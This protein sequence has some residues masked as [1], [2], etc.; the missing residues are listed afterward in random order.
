M[1]KTE[2]KGLGLFI[3][4]SQGS[5]QGGEKD[6]ESTS[7]L[8]QIARCTQAEAVSWTNSADLGFMTL[9]LRTNLLCPF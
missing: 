4:P 1:D 2:W 8:H 3:A 5:V 6:L 7:T 9:A